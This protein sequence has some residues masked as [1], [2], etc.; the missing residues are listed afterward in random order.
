MT[1]SLLACVLTLIVAGSA[2]A[3]I[4][5]KLGLKSKG[6]NDETVA[7]GLKEALTVGTG[8]AVTRTGVV[9]GF[10]KN[11]AIRILMP[12][13]LHTMDKGLRAVGM[14]PKLDEFVLSMNR[15]AERAAPA[16]KAIFKSA[17]G[18]MKFSDVRKIL[19]GGDTAATEYF[20]TKTTARLTESFRPVVSQALGEAGATKQYK[21]LA[22]KASSIP[23]LR[24]PALDLDGYVTGKALYGLFLVL[25]EE[26]RKIR[27]DPAA[28]VTQLLKDV[29]G[30][31]R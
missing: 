13:K 26:E 5:E 11:E 22:A 1:K 15:A 12:E 14:G 29:F 21:G 28:R 8:N 20:R 19:D 10:F 2:D 4:M 25:G 6:P 9:D 3:G 24:S 18:E 30:A 23:F 7:K 16:A 31:K 27:K 17:I